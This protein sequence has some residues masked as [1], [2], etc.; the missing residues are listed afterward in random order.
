M[1]TTCTFCQANA[2]GLTANHWDG[3]AYSRVD[4]CGTCC[5]GPTKQ[6]KRA[7][8]AKRA[9]KVHNGYGDMM[10]VTALPMNRTR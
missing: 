1:T 7:P 2:G 8:R 5:F 4:V 9:P 6:I 10:F 3:A